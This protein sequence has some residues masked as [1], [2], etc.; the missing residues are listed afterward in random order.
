[1]VS[2]F[3]GVWD[4]LIGLSLITSCLINCHNCRTSCSYHSHC[5]CFDAWMRSTLE[6]VK[7][8][9]SIYDICCFS[10][11]SFIRRSITHHYL[12]SETRKQQT[13]QYPN[14]AAGLGGSCCN[15]PS[16][17]RSLKW[18]LVKW[19]CFF[20]GCRCSAFKTT[21]CHSCTTHA[22]HKH[23]HTHSTQD[24]RADKYQV[25]L[26][27]VFKWF[28]SSA[29]RIVRQIDATWNRFGHTDAK[30]FSTHWEGHHPESTDTDTS[31]ARPESD[32]QQR[33]RK[34]VARN[35]ETKHKWMDGKDE[36]RPS[37]RTKSQIAKTSWRESTTPTTAAEERKCLLLVVVV[38][39]EVNRIQC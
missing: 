30:Y 21:N 1:M 31:Q 28:K 2:L 29:G 22:G 25:Q 10:V 18:A 19:E 27:C 36:Q 16:G 14:A 15:V 32:E 13:L 4:C 3:L 6:T 20:S 39:H 38:M 26:P 11:Q 17:R 24:T 23:T 8:S 7:A 5:V 37:E 12:E 9:S 34:R 33:T 35:T